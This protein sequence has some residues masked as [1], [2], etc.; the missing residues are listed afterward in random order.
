MTLTSEGEGRL[1]GGNV[2]RQPK[3]AL[4]LILV[5][6]LPA[7]AHAQ[8]ALPSAT[9]TLDA[10]VKEIRLLRQA[11][12]RQSATTARVQLLI[13]RLTLQDQRTARARQTVERLESDLAGAERERDQLQ[14]AAREM[15]R[16]L[17]QTTDPD[18]RPQL[19]AEARMVR[20]RTVDAQAQLSSTEA[21]LAQARQTLDAE[22]GRYDELEGWLRDLDKQLQTGQ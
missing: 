14:T 9:G 4:G 7:T 17:E 2:K 10:V 19:E 1:K 13:G 12:E 20:A 22:M 16:S 8:A 18:R 6:L 21:R 3:V 5:C 15:A 11:L